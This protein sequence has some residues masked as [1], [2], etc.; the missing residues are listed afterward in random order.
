[1]NAPRIALFGCLIVASIALLFASAEDEYVA[2][3]ALVTFKPNVQSITATT[4]LNRNSIELAETYDKISMH[5][6]RVVGLVRNRQMSTPQL[7]QTLKAD[8]NVETAEPNYIRRV[9]APPPND[10]DFSKLWGLRNTG[11]V[12]NGTTGTSGADINFIPAWKR[13]RQTTNGV[14]VGIVDTGIDLT[15]PD[16]TANIW[17]NPGEVPGNGIDDDGDGYIDDVNGYNFANG[18]GSVT[19]SGYHGT[20]VAGTAGAIGKNL[21]GVIGVNYR[22]KILPLKVSSDGLT[23]T[24]SA[25]IAAYNYAITLKQ[26]G[27][28]IVA[29]NA[30]FGGASPTTA[31]QNAIAALGSAGIV[32]CAAAGNSASNNDSTPFYPSS[33]PAANIISV[34]ALDQN[35]GLSSFSSYGLTTVDLA[36]PGT[37]IYSTEPLSMVTARLSSITVGTSTY[38]TKPLTFSGTTPATGISAYIRSC[39]I[40]NAADFPSNVQGNI[41]LIQRGT[42]DF[43]VKVTNAMNAG[44]IAA[45]IYDNTGNAL[46]AITWTLSTPGAWI[47]SMQITQADG[48]DLLTK[49]G[50][51][52][53]VRNSPDPTQAYQF[54][55]GTSMATPH[56][57]AAVSFAAMNFPT[58]SLSQRITR[59]LSHTTSTA[60]LSGKMT[61]GG[62]LNLLGVV[63][64]DGDGLPDWWETDYFGNLTKTGTQD[65]DADRF[66]NLAEF[67]SGTSPTNPSS[68]L[69]ITQSSRGTGAAANHFKIGFPSV[70]DTSYQ[71]LW[72]ADLMN[73]SI[74]GTTVIGTG[75]LIEVVDQNALSTA[76]KRFYRLYPIPE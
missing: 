49:L 1:M 5:H 68:Y 35:Y 55:N 29:L 54:L 33:Y 2:G 65:S 75:S 69:A 74:L 41:A 48:A 60:S 47:P 18:N 20:H 11:Q 51:I 72:S 13:S 32:L 10:T 76:S 56:V 73:W 27:I 9:F 12:V 24:T 63:D 4:T 45:I 30:S 43:S 16:L 66:D 44:A 22:A 38:Q 28:N 3:E 23:M 17:V 8:P 36:A 42:L 52:G 26:R 6:Q 25:I 7:I 34:A 70:E 57:T 59:I 62:R 64:T 67:L 21:A 50:L 37:N 15:H 71:I 58:D 53:N 39:G 40:G 14:V 61:T 19:D 46:N 31:D